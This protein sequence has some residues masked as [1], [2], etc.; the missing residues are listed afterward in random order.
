MV[1]IS[2]LLTTMGEA[3]FIVRLLLF[4]NACQG[5][6]DKEGC[7]PLHWAAIRGNAEVCN[8]LVQS[9]TKQELTVKDKSGFTP[10]QLASD[11]GQ[12]HAAIILSN[13]TR[14]TGIFCGDRFCMGK[15]AKI[16]YAPILLAFI[17]VP[18]VL[19][20]NS[21]LDAPN[22]TKITAVV[23]LWG[24]TGVSLAVV[25]LFM[26]YRCTSKDP[27]YIKPRF[28]SSSSN[29]S[30]ADALLSIDPYNSPIWTGN[31]S[32][33]C[34]TCKVI[35]PLRSKHCPACKHCVDQFDHHCPWISNCVGKK[36]KWDFF[37]FLCCGSLTSLLGFITTVYRMWT[38]TPVKPSSGRWMHYMATEH[39]GAVAFLVMDSVLLAGALALTITQASQ[40]ARNITTNEMANSARYSYLRSPEGRFRNPYN[41]GCRKNCTDFIINGYT[42]DDELAWPSL[43]QA[44]R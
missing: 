25:S 41:L 37:V 27:G 40:I 29:D 6:Q 5:R 2:M 15:L 10:V 31:W 38:G 4:W 7:T 3:L 36:N 16:G 22:F 33:L 12:K 20:I 39:P 42:N 44:A 24:W 1:L 11:R 17:I 18:V 32:Q 26:F 19:F 34:P 43:Q 23:A 13:A 30:V 28:E 8:V 21:V 14:V 35:R 9:G